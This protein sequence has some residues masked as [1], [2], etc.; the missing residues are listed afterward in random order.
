VSP[1][2]AAARS[3]RP[4]AEAAGQAAGQAPYV[5]VAYELVAYDDASTDGTLVRLR[6]AQP[7]NPRLQVA[8]FRRNGGSGTVRRIGTQQA[9]GQV[10]VWT[11]YLAQTPGGG[12]FPRI[13]PGGRGFGHLQRSTEA[14]RWYIPSLSVELVGISAH[15]VTQWTR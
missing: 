4:A 10:V 13:C 3:P 2:P 9:R 5:T 6:E 11:G 12:V 8:G 7:R 1:A 14:A 15:A